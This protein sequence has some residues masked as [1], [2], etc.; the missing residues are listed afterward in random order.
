VEIDGSIG[1]QLGT[2]FRWTRYGYIL[3][4][5]YLNRIAR[6]VAKPDHLAS[7]AKCKELY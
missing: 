6:P 7:Y 4:S 3:C 2:S 1:P 5:C